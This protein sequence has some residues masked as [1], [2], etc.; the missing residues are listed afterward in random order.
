METIVAASSV[1]C[2]ILNPKPQKV[3]HKP[4][5]L[6][7]S[8]EKLPTHEPSNTG[9][10]IKKRRRRPLNTKNSD[11]VYCCFFCE[12]LKITSTEHVV[13]EFTK[14]APYNHFTG[15]NFELK[16]RIKQLEN[17]NQMLTLRVAKEVSR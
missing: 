11:D 7:L 10:Q 1:S 4:L 8:P 15:E 13:R 17:D 12:L 14:F 9:L 6:K 3:E 16:R 5:E 2:N